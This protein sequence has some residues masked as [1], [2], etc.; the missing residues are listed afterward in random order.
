MR[1]R[2]PNQGFA[3]SSGSP[4]RNR[5]SGGAPLSR[6]QPSPA[7]NAGQLSPQPSSMPTNQYGALIP[8]VAPEGV[9]ALGELRVCGCHPTP[10]TTQP[11]PQ[12]LAAQRWGARRRSVARRARSG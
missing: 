6:H 1:A 12:A 11:V 2:R 10:P 8:A 9:D 4:G 3:A 7:R 5:S